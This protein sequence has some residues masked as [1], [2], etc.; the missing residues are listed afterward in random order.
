MT[1][2]RGMW[3]GPLLLLVALCSSAILIFSCVGTA[4]REEFD[5]GGTDA[6]FTAGKAEKWHEEM[7]ELSEEAIDFLRGFSNRLRGVGRRPG[8]GGATSDNFRF[9][10][11]Y[12]DTH[13]IVRDCD[14]DS[15]W[16]HRTFPFFWTSFYV[17]DD[18]QIA[19]ICGTDE[20]GRTCR[21][22]IYD[23]DGLR[24]AWENDSLISWVSR[25]FPSGHY[26][27]IMGQSKPYVTL[28]DNR[29]EV[30]WV[31]RIP[32]LDGHWAA[33]SSA[34]PDD[35]FVA[36]AVPLIDYPR[37]QEVQLVIIGVDGKVRCDTT[38]SY[39]RFPA[40]RVD[41]EF[42]AVGVANEWLVYRT[43]SGKLIGTL[44]NEKFKALAQWWAP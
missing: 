26:I 19:T 4:T 41:S 39:G 34:S 32:S 10:V 3:I 27:A 13:I 28:V 6:E 30:Q 33:V 15:E 1:T 24:G 9:S 44:S 40:I 8:C 31:K 22:E 35:D 14:G 7:P 12:A 20:L 43:E 36:F 29:G 23:P 5:L 38:L 42:V 16:S 37:T 17:S 18:G 21:L 11:L 25:L 2:G